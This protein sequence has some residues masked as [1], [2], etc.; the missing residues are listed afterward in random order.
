[1]ETRALLSDALEGFASTTLF[2]PIAEAQALL[3]AMAAN[4][5]DTANLRR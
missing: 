2:S 1:V 3:A 4:E 5:P